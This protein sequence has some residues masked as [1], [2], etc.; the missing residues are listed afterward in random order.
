N[1]RTRAVLDCET[2][3]YYWLTVV[4]QDRGAV[5][6]S[7]R[8]DLFVRVDDVN[9]NVPLS[10]EPAYQPAVPENAAPGTSVVQLRAFDL[11]HGGGDAE[12]AFQ[13]TAGDSQGHFAIDARTGQGGS[14][15]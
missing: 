11:D 2:K 5:S 12:L 9:D 6:L 8:L 3:S 13:L 4:A 14:I 1:L 7:S 10:V 15:L